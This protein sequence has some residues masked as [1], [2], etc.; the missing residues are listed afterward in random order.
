[1]IQVD[2][3]V[4]R[5]LNGKEKPMSGN[6]LAKELRIGGATVRKIRDSKEPF[7]I[8]ITGTSKEQLKRLKILEGIQIMYYE[9]YLK[10]QNW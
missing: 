7:V 8:S 9:D 10:E 5:S 4:L 3:D 2:T 6:K 1:M